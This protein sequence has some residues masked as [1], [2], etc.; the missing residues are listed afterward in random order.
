M[1]DTIN[2]ET[3]MSNKAITAN[4]ESSHGIRE[5]QDFTN[6][7]G[8]SGRTVS[9]CIGSNRRL[10][11]EELKQKYPLA[12]AFMENIKKHSNYIKTHG[13]GKNAREFAFRVPHIQ[14]MKEFIDV[15]SRM[16]FIKALE[17]QLSVY[18]DEN[19]G[20]GLLGIDYKYKNGKLIETTVTINGEVIDITKPTR[21]QAIDWYGRLIDGIQ[22]VD[23]NQGRVSRILRRDEKG[24]VVCDKDGNP[25]YDECANS[26]NVVVKLTDDNLSNQVYID[27]ALDRDGAINKTDISKTFMFSPFNFLAV[28]IADDEADEANGH[29]PTGY[30]TPIF[31][32]LDYSHDIEFIEYA[33]IAEHYN[34]LKEQDL[35]YNTREFAG[36][37]LFRWGIID[38]DTW[39]RGVDIYN[40]INNAPKVWGN[41]TQI[42]SKVVY[43]AN[44]RIA[45]LKAR[46]ETKDIDIDNVVIAGA[47]IS[48]V[49]NVMGQAY[50]R[51]RAL[52]VDDLKEDDIS[53]R[54]TYIT[55]R[56]KPE[57]TSKYQTISRLNTDIYKIIEC[58]KDGNFIRILNPIDVFAIVNYD[59]DVVVV[60]LE[61]ELVTMEGVVPGEVKPAA[62]HLNYYNAINAY[63]G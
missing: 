63:K 42:D 36:L 62:E 32:K 56:S 50:Y 4:N 37:N 11:N 1:V 9:E 43:W 8:Y 12:K 2:Q 35:C 5:L 27:E 30:D 39:L 51:F 40:A 46:A 60:K 45:E 41:D 34:M 29:F 57:R 49:V 23:G 26:V 61:T 24:A 3:T 25:Q 16:Q 54:D 28:R 48:K 22:L 18:K 44:E 53:F 47:S 31:K 15:S 7:F 38:R 14:A 19:I 17:N 59:I 20:W 10:T 58:D 6:F 21:I 13:G 33:D 55:L 52:V